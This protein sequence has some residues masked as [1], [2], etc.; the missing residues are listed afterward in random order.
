MLA[1]QPKAENKDPVDLR[2][3]LKQGGEVVSETMDP[4]IGPRHEH[5]IRGGAAAGQT[6]RAAMDSGTPPPTSRSSCFRPTY[7]QSRPPRR[8][9]ATSPRPRHAPLPPKM[10]ER[11]ATE[12]AA[13][14]MDLLVTEWFAAVLERI[15]TGI[16]HVLN[17]RGRLAC[18]WPTCRAN[19]GDQFLRPGR[20]PRNLWTPCRTPTCADRISRSRRWRPRLLDLGPITT[21][22]NL[23]TPAK[24]MIT[25]WIAFSSCSARSSC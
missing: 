3:T 7:P 9:R 21:L 11:T 18:C 8:T 23:E 5:A 22:T 13:E 14:E 6:R 10:P 17:T 12:L 19:G 15:P 2:C 16:E 20:G 1:M 25:I 24:Q 4:T